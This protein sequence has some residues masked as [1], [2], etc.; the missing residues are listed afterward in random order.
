MGALGFECAA[1]VVY[2]RSGEGASGSGLFVAWVVWTFWGFLFLHFHYPPLSSL[3]RFLL[4]DVYIA[5]P[6]W[7]Q[8]DTLL[9]GSLPL[10]EHAADW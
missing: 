9:L 1:G 10:G 8:S 3:G 5:P 7:C 2:T 6:L 4:F